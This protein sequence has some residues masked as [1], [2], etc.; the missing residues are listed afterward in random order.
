MFKNGEIKGFCH[1]YDGEEAVATGIES[2]LT[3]EDCFITTYRCHG[4]AF[5]RGTSLFKILSEALGKAT[6]TSK[7]KGGSMHLYNAAN[8]FYGGIAIIGAQIPLGA[9][10]AFAL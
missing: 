10:F 8:H 9:G 6:G 2:A 5:T 1:L 4:H 7:G 3:M